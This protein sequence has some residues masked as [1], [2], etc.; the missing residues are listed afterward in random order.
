MTEM[1][2][3]EGH[4]N[5]VVINLLVFQCHFL[6]F[7]KHSRPSKFQAVC[8]NIVKVFGHFLHLQVILNVGFFQI[9]KVYPLDR[10]S[11]V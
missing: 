11:V 8:C 6:I 4:L 10:K 5:S 7:R 3:T 9:I 2:R 1:G